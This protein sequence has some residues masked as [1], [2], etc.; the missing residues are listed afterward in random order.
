MKPLLLKQTV[1]YLKHTAIVS[2]KKVKTKKKANKY[3]IY[4]SI[5]ICFIYLH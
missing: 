2:A 1:D 3:W 4:L 5:N